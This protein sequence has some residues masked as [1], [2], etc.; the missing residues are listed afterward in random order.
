MQEWKDANAGE[1]IM[2]GQDKQGVDSDEW[3]D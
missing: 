3:D 2:P 1:V